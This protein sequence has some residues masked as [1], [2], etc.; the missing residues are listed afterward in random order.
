MINFFLSL[1]LYF[2]SEARTSLYVASKHTK[3]IKTK[4]KHNKLQMKHFSMNG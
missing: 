2:Y 3:R 1:F 4:Q